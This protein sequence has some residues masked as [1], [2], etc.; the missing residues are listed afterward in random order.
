MWPMSILVSGTFTC[1]SCM[2]TLCCVVS[3]ETIADVVS[4][5]SERWTHWLASLCHRQVVPARRLWA[6]GSVIHYSSEFTNVNS[7]R[8]GAATHRSAGQRVID[9]CHYQIRIYCQLIA[10]PGKISRKDN[11][12]KNT[13][14][15]V[16][17]RCLTVES[18][19]LASL[20]TLSV[21]IVA[22]TQNPLSSQDEC[23]QVL[24][25]EISHS[26]LHSV[27]WHSTEWRFEWFFAVRP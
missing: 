10:T 21:K 13:W 18:A 25:G 27:H 9:S 16:Q 11:K 15:R 17:E 4:F 22:R 1:P 20:T 26:N 14:G 12:H 2:Y 8:R 5:V 6:A 23:T 24:R 19:Y 7:W 3:L